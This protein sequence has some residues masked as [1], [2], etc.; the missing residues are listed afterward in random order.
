[1]KLVALKS[2]EKFITSVIIAKR[3]HLDMARYHKMTFF[4]LC[5]W[6]VIN[7]F[8]SR[9]HT[10]A[11]QKKKMINEKMCSFRVLCTLQA[12]KITLKFQNVVA[13]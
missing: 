12:E 13:V 2:F 5:V 1:M 3:F 6:A 9:S 10:Q 4:S 8:L 7:S 11:R